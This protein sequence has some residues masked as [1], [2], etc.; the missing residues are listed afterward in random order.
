[1][2]HVVA[3]QF[4]WLHRIKGLPP[5]DVKLWGDYS[6]PQLVKMAEDAGR[7]WLEFIEADREF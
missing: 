4:L 7:L 5:A 3:A 2:G 1:M 6:L